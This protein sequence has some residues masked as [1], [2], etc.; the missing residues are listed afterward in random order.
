MTRR[1]ETL[2]GLLVGFASLLFGSVVIFGRYVLREGVTV[3]SMLAMRF[4]IAA[5]LLAVAL[6]LSRRPLLAAPGERL[7][8]ALLAI[9][10]YAVESALF[11]TAV[12]HGTAAAVT[13]LFYT[14]PA[15][16]TLGVWVLGRGA[17][18]GM[19]ILALG[20]A[21]GGTTVVVGFAGGL[22]VEQIGAALALG[23]AVTYAAYLIGADIVIER[24]GPMTSAM[25]VSGGASLALLTLALGTGEWA[26]PSTW[27]GWWPLLC[28][29]AATAAAFVCLLAGLQRLG[30]VRTS[31]V[32][33]TEPLSTAL[34]A[35][36][37]LDE[38]VALA[39]LAGGAL[40]LAGAVVA[41]L[42]RSPTAQE[43][44]IP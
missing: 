16:V 44:Q 28:M 5:V 12:E 21:V 31:I 2:G 43:Q 40:I 42:A 38:S 13:L 30:A 24:T 9:F 15:L 39:T 36:V 14:Y 19:T 34:L 23:S 17:P 11:F 8:L 7:R 1:E 25:W 41:S 3:P 37:F 32:A 27:D 10:G 6:I 22:A 4:G 18:A 20:C 26:P 33:A 35:F 29:G